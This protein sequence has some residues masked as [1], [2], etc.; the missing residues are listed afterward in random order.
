MPQVVLIK[1]NKRHRPFRSTAEAAKQALKTYY[2]S[3]KDW[4]KMKKTKSSRIK[5][6][7]PAGV[8]CLKIVHIE[9]MAEKDES[10][11][12]QMENNPTVKAIGQSIDEEIHELLK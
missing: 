2:N 6:E 5:E 9:S 8:E 1:Q 11:E 7:V 4:T 10:T 12:Q 3:D